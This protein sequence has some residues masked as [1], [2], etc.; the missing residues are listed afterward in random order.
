MTAL[1][2]G[3]RSMSSIFCIKDLLINPSTNSLATL[4]K[5]SRN[6]SQTFLSSSP[7]TIVLETQKSVK[8]Y[9]IIIS[10]Q[11]IFRKRQTLSK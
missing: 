3:I 9:S 2:F 4:S 5:A 7:S 11:P 10:A 8:H 1:T 6:L